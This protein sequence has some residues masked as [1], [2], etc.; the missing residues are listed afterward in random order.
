M[1]HAKKP[2]LLI[3]E[4]ASGKT[5]FLRNFLRTQDNSNKMTHLELMSLSHAATAART[6]SFIEHRL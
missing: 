5:T 6:Q 1:I 2:V 4:S 3:G